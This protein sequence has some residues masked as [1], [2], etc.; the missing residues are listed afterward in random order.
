VLF[1]SAFGWTGTIVFEDNFDGNSLDLSKWH[2]QEGCSDI[3]GARNLQCYT[4]DNIAVRDGNLIITARPERREDKD[5]T[6]GRIRQNGVG[7]LYGAYVV[8]ARLARG[9]HLWPAIWM[10][11]EDNACRYEEIDIAEYRGQA[12]QWNQLEQAAH[13]GKAWYALTSKGVR[14][15]IPF[16]MTTAYHEYAVLWLPSKIE[17]YI[18][19]VKYYE[20]SLTDPS[21]TSNPENIPCTGDRTPF[22]WPG[23]FILNVA[24][25][26]PFFDEFP[27]FDPSTWSKPTMEVDWVRVYQE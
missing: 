12:T 4:R 11:A 24:V 27:N 8:R 3:Y 26:G 15:T 16:D 5:Y 20:V 21:W 1:A 14:N 22:N 23:T 6:S 7:N 13:W 18:D 10:M 9:D 2:Y 19:D 17:W 25:G